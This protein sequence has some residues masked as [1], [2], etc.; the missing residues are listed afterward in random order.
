MPQ[1]TDTP[2]VAELPQG[3]ETP[4]VTTAGEGE[5]RD[6]GRGRGGDNPPPTTRETRA[7]GAGGGNDER[8]SGP[9]TEAD[10]GSTGTPTRH[11]A[12]TDGTRPEHGTL[13]HRENGLLAPT[14]TAVDPANTG[15]PGSEDRHET[16]GEHAGQDGRDTDEGDETQQRALPVHGMQGDREKGMGPPPNSRVR[17][18]RAAAKGGKEGGNPHPVA[19]A[20]VTQRG[21]RGGPPNT[22]ARSPTVRPGAG[23]GSPPPAPAARA[24]RA[25][26]GGGGRHSFFGAGSLL[27]QKSGTPRPLEW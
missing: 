14:G 22:A 18:M 10:D 12:N 16:T 8:M 24:T 17:L 7:Q 13:A 23:G 21:T 25:R 19:R 15:D 6:D 9:R 11:N 3:D 2:G 20:H 4:V 1:A 5:P 26:A 27:S